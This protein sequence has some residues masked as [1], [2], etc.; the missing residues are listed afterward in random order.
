[1]LAGAALSAVA[2]HYLPRTR[3]GALLSRH[4]RGSVVGASLIGL[5]S[6]LCTFAA[7]PV[8]SRVMASGVPAAPLMA[9]LFASPLMNPAL[10]V[11]TQGA[12]GLEMAVARTVTALGIGLAAGF[13]TAALQGRGWL[14]GLGTAPF[15]VAGG[16]GPAAA[17]APAGPALWRRFARDL[18]FI[19][20]WFALGLFLAAL[21]STF[22]TPEM[23]RA[24]LGSGNRWSIPSA[25]ALGV[26]LYACGGA[27]IPI[28]ET[29]VRMGMAPGAAL[30]FFIAGPAT[31][32]HTVGTLGAVFGRRVLAWYLLVMLLGALLCG[33]LYP[34]D[35]PLRTPPYGELPRDPF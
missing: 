3:L 2:S 16:S 25:V 35:Q 24:V 10:F 19:S 26:P 17:E 15:A 9:F 11:Y 28:V 13:G 18:S 29:M 4:R 27:A 32:L 34:F 12:L 20:R 1:M 14:A 30:A 31:K 8:V 33:S 21:V 22:L 23:I 7:I 6:P 5:V